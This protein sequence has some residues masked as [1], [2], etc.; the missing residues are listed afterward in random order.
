M[1]DRW[2]AEDE[3]IE[4]AA[5]YDHHYII[6]GFGMRTFAQADCTKT[7]IHLEVKSDMPGMQLYTGNFLNDLPAGKGGALCKNCFLYGNPVYS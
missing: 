3:Q 2:D 6:E 5:G 1:A 4:L 7:G